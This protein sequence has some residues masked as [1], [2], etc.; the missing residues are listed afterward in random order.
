MSMPAT[1]A[2][3]TGEVR[4]TTCDVEMQAVPIRVA[5][6]PGDK[7]E[8]GDTRAL[9]ARPVA[10]SDRIVP[11]VMSAIYLKIVNNGSIPSESGSWTSG[12]EKKRGTPL[13]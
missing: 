11:V 5:G 6:A 4:N 1:A 7:A 3:S 8:G 12:G 10:T 2:L 13:L 9:A